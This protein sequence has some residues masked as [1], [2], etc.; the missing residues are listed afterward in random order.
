VLRLNVEDLDL[1][2]RKARVT[3][4]GGAVDVIVW[5]SGTARPR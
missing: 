2:N 1:P 4:K 3:R 5:Q